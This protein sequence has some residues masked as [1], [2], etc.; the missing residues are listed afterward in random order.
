VDSEAKTRKQRINP[1]LTAAGWSVRRFEH[2]FVGQ[3]PSQSAVEEWPTTVGPADYALCEAGSVLGIVEAKKLT[4]GAQ[5][6]LPQAER[7]SRAI[8]SDT[9]YQGEFGV[10]FLYSTNGEEIWF[11]DVRQSLNRSRRVLGF[12]TPGALREQ[13]DRDFD[14]EIAALR[15]FRCTRVFGRTRSRP[16]PRSKRPSRIGNARCW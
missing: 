2:A 9:R 15:T 11:H 14:A 12:H 1:R 10:P 13:L 6:V 3:P 8:R 7:Y 16:T 5:G 4:I